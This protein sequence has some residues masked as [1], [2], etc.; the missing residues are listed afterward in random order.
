MTSPLA[1]I[2]RREMEKYR[3]DAPIS[4]KDLKATNRYLDSISSY[5]IAVAIRE[6]AIPHPDYPVHPH[7]YSY[8]RLV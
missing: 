7:D 6:V 4:I 2:I 1:Q 3:P 5:T 8:W